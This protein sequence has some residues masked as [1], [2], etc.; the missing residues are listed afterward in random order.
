M[1]ETMFPAIVAPNQ[2]ISFSCQPPDA[3]RKTYLVIPNRSFVSLPVHLSLW[4]RP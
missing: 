2:P 3:F 4:V 1:A